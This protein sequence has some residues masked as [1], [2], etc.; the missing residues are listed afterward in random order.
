MEIIMPL[1]VGILFA[2]ALY[3]MLQPNLIRVALGLIL[4]TN[5]T[6]LF[7]FS[8][9]R[10][11]KHGPPIIPPDGKILEQGY[12]NPVS[13][14]LILTAIVIGFGLLSFAI[15]LIYRTVLEFESQNSEVIAHDE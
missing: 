4:L 9:G 14:A 6:N 2:G 5:A 10:L 7:L 1:L 8:G 3:M 12:A 13:Q 11:T 15:A